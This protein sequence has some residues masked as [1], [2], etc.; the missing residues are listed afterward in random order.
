MLTLFW[1]SEFLFVVWT[2]WLLSEIVRAKMFV[3]VLITVPALLLLCV[4]CFFTIQ[5]ALGLPAHQLPQELSLLKYRTDGHLIWVWGIEK[6]NTAP[7]SYEVP[8]TKQ[9]H[10]QLEKGAQDNKQNG[11]GTAHLKKK[12][13]GT[14][15]DQ[16]SDAQFVEYQFNAA[17]SL[18]AKAPNL[19][20]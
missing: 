8:Y 5:G 20:Q 11:E 13:K 12:G 7:T 19:E 14:P 2:L 4:A 10:E 1:V 9:L 6:G 18:P 17:V 15:G 16:Q 3:K